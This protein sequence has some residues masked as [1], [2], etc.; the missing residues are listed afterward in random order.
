MPETKTITPAYVPFKTFTSVIDSFSSFLP[1]QIDPTVW[2]SYSGGMKSQLLGALKFLGLISEDGKPTEALRSLAHTDPQQRP[3]KFR[4]ILKGAYSSLMSLDLTKATPG[5][6]DAEMRRYGQEGE[7]HRKAS[8]FFLQAAKWSGV[9]LS[10]LLMK[11]GS[12]AGSRRKRATNGASAKAKTETVPK[13]EMN[14]ATDPAF[15]AT[16]PGSNREILLSGGGKMILRTDRDLFQMN[17]IDRKFV[18]EIL[19]RLETYESEH[20]AADGDEDGA[21]K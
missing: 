21:D 4:E 13:H 18:M 16:A 11:K 1:D 7:T 2:P 19:E 3:A 20:P 12:L 17:A 6:F 14:V 8:S 9:P 5:S 15:S 10:P